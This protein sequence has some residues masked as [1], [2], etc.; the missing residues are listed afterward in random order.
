[1]GHANVSS[2]VHQVAGA[3]VPP[4][5]PIAI[6]ERI[7]A[8]RGVE[9]L[10]GLSDRRILLAGFRTP[11]KHSPMVRPPS[12][13]KANPLTIFTSSSWGKSTSTGG[14]WVPSPC[15]SAGLDRLQES[16]LIRGWW[17][18]PERALARATYGSLISMRTNSLRCFSQSLPWLSAVC[19]SCSIGCEISPAPINRRKSLRH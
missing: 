2:E 19:R 16:S 9:A 18:G 17:P 5:H 1:M 13:G 3:A 8:L 6:S 10:Q 14:I 12:S 11:L 7:A 15:L 4:A